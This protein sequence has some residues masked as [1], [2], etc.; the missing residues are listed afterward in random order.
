M[1]PAEAYGDRQW[2][3]QLPALNRDSIASLV[4]LPQDWYMLLVVIVAVVHLVLETVLRLKS[5]AK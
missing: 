3:E 4:L 1:K 5:R 2:L